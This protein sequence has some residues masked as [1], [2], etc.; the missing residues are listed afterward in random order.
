MQTSENIMICRYNGCAVHFV[1]L[2]GSNVTINEGMVEC[3][4]PSFSG[5]RMLSTEV[6]PVITPGVIYIV[7]AE[8]GM[9]YSLRK[10]FLIPRTCHINNDGSVRYYSGLITTADLF[11]SEEEEEGKSNS[12]EECWKDI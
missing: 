2:F 11:A 5:M 1:N 12:E 6:A 8:V 9:R 10:D 3:I 7:S 4:I